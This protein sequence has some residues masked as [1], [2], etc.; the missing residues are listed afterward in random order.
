M[1]RDDEIG[2][3][4]QSSIAEQRREQIIAAAVTLF[5]ERGYFQTTIE[6]ISNAIG[7]G[8]GLIYRYFKDK[9]DVLLSALCSVLR[10]N[11]Q[12]NSMQQLS[13]SGPI[14]TLRKI[15]ANS[16]AMAHENTEAVIL[17]YRSTKDLM[18]KQRRQVKDIELGIA[19]DIELCLDACISAGLMRP[20]DVR[21]MAFQYIMLGHTWALKHWALRNN[22]SMESFLAEGERLLLLPFLTA[23][24]RRKL[25]AENKKRQTLAGEKKAAPPKQSGRAPR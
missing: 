17:A 2:D 1:A 6:D 20:L 8:K 23:A 19:R 15:L 16:C 21:I 3:Q 25:A 14:A 11:Q 24:G 12:E 5:S 10:G 13:T 9:N 22:Y 4:E 7:V 18:P